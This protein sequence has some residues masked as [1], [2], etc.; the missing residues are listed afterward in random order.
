MRYS[1]EF[2]KKVLGTGTL[3]TEEVLQML[4]TGDPKIGKA[5]HEGVR[6]KQV[7]PAL[8]SEWKTRFLEAEALSP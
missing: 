7:D 4:E 8:Y 5:I 3:A 1:D 6:A 2:K